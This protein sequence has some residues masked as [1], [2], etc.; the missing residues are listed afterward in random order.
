MKKNYIK[1]EAAL[2]LFLLII[3]CNKDVHITSDIPKVTFVTPSI[4]KVFTESDTVFLQIKIEAI[5]EIHDY[6]I[7][8]MNLTEGTES[9]M[10]YGHSDK[11]VALTEVN[12]IPNVNMDAE[13]QIVVTTLNHN[14]EKYIS[15]QNFKVLNTIKNTKPTIEILSP[16]DMSFNNGDIL[17]V[18]ASIRHIDFLENVFLILLQNNDTILNLRPNVIGLK[19][20][21]FDTSYTINITA[22]ANFNLMVGVTDTN[23]ISNLKTTNFH[24]HR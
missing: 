5:N 16:T 3:A 12:F 18:K 23:E 6:S 11:N 22:D 15:T 21:T 24:V 13:M 19:N 1:I 17:N 2:V 4:N 8:V 10:C 7:Q 14:G 9:Y 20:Y